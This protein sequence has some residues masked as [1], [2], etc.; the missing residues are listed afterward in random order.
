MGKAF[1]QYCPIAHALSIVG[2]RWSLLL[3]RELLKGPGATPTWRRGLPGIGTN[4]LASRLRELEAGGVVRR[5][6]LPPPP[7][8]PSTS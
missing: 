6:K 2:E 7:P 5:R 1:D 4:I 3:V 8:R